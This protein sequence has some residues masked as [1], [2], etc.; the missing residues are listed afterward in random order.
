M[1]NPKIYIVAVIL[2]IIIT[3]TFINTNEK[4][5]LYKAQ[6]DHCLKK[7]SVGMP[8]S[9]DV[10]TCNKI[11]EISRRSENRSINRKKLLKSFCNDNG[12]KYYDQGSLIIDIKNNIVHDYSMGIEL[13]CKSGRIIN[14]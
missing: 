13:H 5:Y 3:T 2:I 1:N 14:K 12:Y 7:L 8:K 4:D 10:E 6:M 9:Y 11:I